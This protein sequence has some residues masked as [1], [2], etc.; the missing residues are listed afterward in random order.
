MVVTPTPSSTVQQ[1]NIDIQLVDIVG[2]G[3]IIE[4]QSPL[5]IPLLAR[6]DSLYRCF[7]IPQFF[8]QSR[9]RRY[10]GG[11]VDCNT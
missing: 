7:P 1:F 3:V 9:E 6:Y 4:V 5:P 2:D 10:G 8:R 11:G